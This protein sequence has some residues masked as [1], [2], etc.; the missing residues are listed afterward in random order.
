MDDKA[1]C[2]A[3]RTSWGNWKRCILI[4][5]V[6]GEHLVAEHKYPTCDQI[7]G[8]HAKH[9]LCMYLVSIAWNLKLVSPTFWAPK[10]LT[11]PV[12]KRIEKW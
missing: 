2:V 9:S 5:Q 11:T 3:C 7:V 6:I 10:E 1:T 12:A 8:W 4:L